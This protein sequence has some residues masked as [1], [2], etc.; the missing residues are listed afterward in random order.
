MMS[1]VMVADAQVPAGGDAPSAVRKRL[2]EF[3]GEVLSVAM[4][5]PTQTA[6]GGLCLRGLIEDGARKSLEP[7]VSR[8][9]DEADYQSMHTWAGIITPHWLPPP[10]ASSPSSDFT[11]KPGGRPDSPEDRA[12]L[13]A[14]LQMLDRPLPDVSATHRA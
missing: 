2:E 13:A 1:A 10:T 11:Q 7:M 4:N 9:G 5:R 3:A 8:L 6:N 12:A 14:D